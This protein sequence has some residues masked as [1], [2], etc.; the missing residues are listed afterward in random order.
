MSSI[1]SISAAASASTPSS[2]AGAGAL[3]FDKAKCEASLADW[4]HCVSASTPQ[5]KARI[6]ELST[7]LRGIEA[8]IRKA[9]ESKTD[10]DRS[11]PTAERPSAPTDTLGNLVDEYA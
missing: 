7:Q 2:I 1:G 9:A 11:K 10:N 8:Q 5:G 6:Q 4:V 3:Q